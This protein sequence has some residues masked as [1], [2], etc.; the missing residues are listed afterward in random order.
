MSHIT[1]VCD[2]CGGTVDGL[3]DAAT[4]PRGEA[5]V[6]TGGFQ[7]HENGASCD[8]CVFGDTGPGPESD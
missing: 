2:E 6:L 5:V 3:I 8:D 7:L 4:A 1:V